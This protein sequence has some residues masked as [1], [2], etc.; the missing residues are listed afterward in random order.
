MNMDAVSLSEIIGA[1]AVVINLAVLVSSARNRSAIFELKDYLKDYMREN[2]VHK[3][4]VR[5][6]ADYNRNNNRE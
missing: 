6:A 5:R 3:S 2:F 1:V 4:D